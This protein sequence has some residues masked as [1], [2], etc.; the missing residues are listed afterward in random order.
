MIWK[1]EVTLDALNA[2][3]EGNMVGLLDIHFEHIG[4]DT[5]EATMPSII[6]PNN[7][8]ACCMA[9]RLWYWR[10]VSVRSQAICVRRGSKRW[11][12]WR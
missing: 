5:L 2:M 9:E 1:R 6:A 10:K 3:G 11:W 12:V 8:S 7:R 4:D